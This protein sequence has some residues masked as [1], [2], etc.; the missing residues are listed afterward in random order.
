MHSP[1]YR[2]V[3]TKIKVNVEIRLEVVIIHNLTLSNTPHN[4]CLTIERSENFALPS[5][6]ST[7]PVLILI[8]VEGIFCGYA[9]HVDVQLIRKVGDWVWRISKDVDVFAV[10]VPIRCD[11]AV[12]GYLITIPPD[13]ILA[14]A[15]GNM[16]DVID[17]LN[18]SN[19]SALIML[20][21]ILKSFRSIKYRVGIGTTY[22]EIIKST[23]RSIRINLHDARPSKAKGIG[24]TPLLV[25]WHKLLL[26][27][28]R[29][30]IIEM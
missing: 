28:N 7:P 6:L 17:E 20:I 2:S 26:V 22:N 18:F 25:E 30:I 23:S 1:P 5:F 10:D 11:V 19:T 13:A 24:L 16:G 27:R 15:I 9:S 8:K 4:S 21:V 14:V 3:L 29:L 12:L